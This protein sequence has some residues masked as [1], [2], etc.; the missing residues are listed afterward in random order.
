MTTTQAE[1]YY[2]KVVRDVVS[3]IDFDSR[4]NDQWS[5]DS[6]GLSARTHDEMM[7]MGGDSMKDKE[8]EGLR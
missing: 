5:V 7:Y 8:Q 4:V 2:E 1:I 6:E 3:K